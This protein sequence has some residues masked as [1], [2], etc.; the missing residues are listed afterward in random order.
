MSA[1][2][3]KT[4]PTTIFKALKIPNRC[5]LASVVYVVFRLNNCYYYRDLH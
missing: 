1:T 5:K 4:F 3:K 2:R